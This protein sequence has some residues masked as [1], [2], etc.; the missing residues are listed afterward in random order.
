MA[1][2]GALRAARGVAFD[3]AANV[4]VGNGDEEVRAGVMVHGD[5]AAGLEFEFGNTDGV[6]DEENLLSATLEDVKG[7][8]LIPMGRRV[9]ERFVLKD[10]YGDVAERLV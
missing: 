10:F 9:A 7:A 2:H 4:E 6:F 5:N 3:V 1:G 8:V